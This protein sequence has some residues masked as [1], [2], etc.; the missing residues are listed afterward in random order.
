M[1]LK[2]KNI[3]NIKYEGVSINTKTIKKNDIFFCIK[4]KK[5]DGHNF[6]KEAI[7]RGAI[8]LIISKKIK[9][10]PNSRFIKV[11]NTFSSLNSLA[12][13]TRDNSSAQIIGIT[14]SVG[15][16]TL[17]NLI[18]FILKNYGKTYHS[19]FSYNNKFG[20]P[21]SLAN[22]K[23]ILNMEYLKLEWIKKVR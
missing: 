11:K 14:G 15:K 4:G 16:T 6:A 5:N 22:L 8:R 12:Q 1:A 2:K 13:T 17:K 21:L 3:K 9:K 19:P 10:L 18:G 23:K 7:K 20:V